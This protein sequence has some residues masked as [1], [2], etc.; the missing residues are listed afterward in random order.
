M[1]IVQ[2]ALPE[3][4]EIVLDH[5]ILAKLHET[6]TTKRRF[7][8]SAVQGAGNVLGECGRSAS[9]QRLRESIS[10]LRIGGGKVDRADLR[11][12]GTLEKELG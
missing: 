1:N 7:W 5:T 2:S 4:A 3:S 8:Y 9:R 6:M 12:L 11:R 10:A